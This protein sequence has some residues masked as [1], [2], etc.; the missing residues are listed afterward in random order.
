MT[1]TASSLNK[2]RVNHHAKETYPEEQCD[3][4]DITLTYTTVDE[5]YH[6]VCHS[7]RNVG[8]RTKPMVNVIIVQKRRRS[9]VVA[10]VVDVGRRVIIVI[11]IFEHFRSK[12]EEE[13]I[14]VTVRCRET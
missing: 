11:F 8:R 7:F 14:V 1:E 10:V 3:N 5:V 12:Y 6:V 2:K 13:I 9:F 4:N